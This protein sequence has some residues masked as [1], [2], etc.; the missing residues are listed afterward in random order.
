MLYLDYGKEPGQWVPN[1]NGGNE[2]LEAVEFFKHLNTLVRGRNKGVIMIAEESTTWP[3]VTGSVEDGGLHFSYKW[4]MGWMHD[5]LDYMKLD[6]YFRKYNHNKMTFGMTYAFSENYILV[7]SHDEVVHLKCSMINKMPGDL[8]EKFQ[9]LMVGYAFMFGHPGKKLL[10]MGQDF[11]QLREWSEEREI[12]WFLHFY[13]GIQPAMCICYDRLALFDKYQPE[14]RVTFDSG[15]RW[16]MDDLD[17]SSG[18]AGEHLLPHDT[19]LMEIKIPGT[20]P[21]W[22]ARV[23]SENAIF[24]T[25]FSKYGAA[26]QTM[27]RE[28]RSPQ[29]GSDTIHINEKGEIYCA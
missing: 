22:L 21:L 6:P 29:F 4:N 18:S 1:K 15:I 19:C 5:F 10:F 23:L 12:D 14:L 9:N 28:D 25:H 17:L 3:K 13:K 27:L 11:G 2:N 7:L 20:T 24:P 26:Y 8:E 16:R